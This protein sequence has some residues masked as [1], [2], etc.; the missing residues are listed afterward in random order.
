MSNVTNNIT[1]YNTVYIYKS[2][3]GEIV[4][5]KEDPPWGSTTIINNVEN[6]KNKKQK[7]SLK[8]NLLYLLL[9]LLLL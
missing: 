7:N 1:V 3:N 9:Y 8:K 2:I 5:T 6:S 4:E